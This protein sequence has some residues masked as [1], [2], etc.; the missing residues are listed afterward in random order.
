[1]LEFSGFQRKTCP[2]AARLRGVRIFELESTGHQVARV[3]ERGTFQ[4]FRRFWVADYG[5]SVEILDQ[6]GWFGFGFDAHNVFKSRAP[7]ALNPNPQNGTWVA[8]SVAHALD[9]GDRFV[10]QSYGEHCA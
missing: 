10:G 6:I 7:A 1:M 2:A 4:N 3:N 8:F 9:L 5:H